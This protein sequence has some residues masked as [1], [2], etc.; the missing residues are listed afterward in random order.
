MACVAGVKGLGDW[1]KRGKGRGKWK[2]D[3]E[4]GEKGGGEKR[5]G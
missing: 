3:W 5:E 1:E 4:E 2:W